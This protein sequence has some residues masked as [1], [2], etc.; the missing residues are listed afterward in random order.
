MS[1]NLDA[2]EPGG[3]N[4]TGSSPFDT[5]G[6]GGSGVTA[7]LVEEGV[8]QILRVDAVLA[9]V[10]ANRIYPDEA[11]TKAVYPLV[12]Y[13][14][15][16]EFEEATLEEPGSGGL[17]RVT[18]LLVAVTQGKANKGECKRVAD[19]V[20]QALI[21]FQGGYVEDPAVSG[22]SI[23]IQKIFPADVG[24]DKDYDSVTQVYRFART[25]NVW[26]VKPVP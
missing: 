25:F 11:P 18:M 7:M 2:I 22:R 5:V 14:Q 3:V 26:A 24:V 20:R 6:T 1:T 12:Y 17:T 13:E 21:G 8:V 4:E 23:Q 10:I 15:D 19:L 9:P 16:D